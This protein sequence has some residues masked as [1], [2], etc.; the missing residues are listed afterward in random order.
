MNPVPVM[1]TAIPP[2][3]TGAMVRTFLLGKA[4][5]SALANAHGVAVDVLEGE[6][7]VPSRAATDA[8]FDR[9]RDL[10]IDRPQLAALANRP[11]EMHPA[12]AH[13]PIFT[14]HAVWRSPRSGCVRAALLR[15]TEGQF[16]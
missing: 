13:E 2:A 4:G 10:L 9:D 3:I 12:L 5:V 11:T 1:V 16:L 8:Y 15:S 6:A 14:H 7:P